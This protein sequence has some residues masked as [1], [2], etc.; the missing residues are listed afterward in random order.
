[1]TADPSFLGALLCADESGGFGE[2]STTYDERVPIIN[3]VNEM[4]PGLTQEKIPATLTRQY[5]NEGRYGVEGTYG[6][7]FSV[8][9]YLTGLGATTAGALPSAQISTSLTRW[10]G[11]STLT[12]DGGTVASATDADTFVSTNATIAAGSLLR[13][14]ASGDARGAGQFAATSA[15]STNLELWTAIGATPS[16]SDV[17]WAIANIYPDETTHTVTSERFQLLTANQCYDAHGCWCSGLSITG[18]NPGEVPVLN[19][20]ISC[21]RWAVNDTPPTFPTA[22][23]HSPATPP[24]PPVMADGSF[25]YQTYGTST[26]STQNIRDIE[27]NIN[28][29]TIPLLSPETSN[30]NQAIADVR[31]TRVGATF[32]F[33]IDGEAAGTH[34]L[35]DD[36]DGTDYQHALWTGSCVDGAAIGIYMP[37]CKVVGT[38]PTQ[39]DAGGVTGT[40]VT[41]ECLTRTGGADD[42]RKAPFIIGLG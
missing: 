34:I 39:M 36:W 15:A 19:A 37:Y 27:F 30:A 29:E 31:R 7:T 41:L 35:A 24:T 40:R 18:M 16:A 14:G 33:T 11:A 21:A 3:S 17:I 4:I 23:A 28:V 38:R 10:I 32:S 13:V 26:R 22:Q 5:P 25:F 9:Q 8:S 1:M 42:L 12:N 2:S 20:D 6:G